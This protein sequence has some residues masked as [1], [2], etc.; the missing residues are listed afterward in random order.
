MIERRL[1]ARP[2]GESRGRRRRGQFRC[3]QSNRAASFHDLILR[4]PPRRH[5]IQFLVRRVVGLEVPDV[6]PDRL[7]LLRRRQ[8][9]EAFVQ[10]VERAGEPL[11][12][13]ALLGRPRAMRRLSVS[14]LRS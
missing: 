7:G 3:H 8:A 2:S 13:V 5:L 12:M 9:A 1:E 4:L 6:R 14:I 10:F 11:V